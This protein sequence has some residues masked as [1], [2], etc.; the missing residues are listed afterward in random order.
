MRLHPSATQDAAVS[1]PPTLLIEVSA[2]LPPHLDRD[3]SWPDPVQFLRDATES[4][5][6]SPWSID[7]VYDAGFDEHT[8]D[9]AFWFYVGVQSAEV[10]PTGA[11]GILADEYSTR[12]GT[13][14]TRVKFVVPVGRLLSTERREVATA[15]CGHGENHRYHVCI[16]TGESR[17]PDLWAADIVYPDPPISHSFSDHVWNGPAKTR[18]TMHISLPNCSLQEIGERTAHIAASL[19]GRG[20]REPIVVDWNP[21]REY[22]HESARLSASNDVSSTPPTP[23]PS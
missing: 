14:P 15:I 10:M 19:H 17:P 13:T 2:D 21:T 16:D 23:N 9:A 5:A 7:D 12:V 18:I 11:L 20:W 3:R 6:S 8:P 1:C 22:D 4:C